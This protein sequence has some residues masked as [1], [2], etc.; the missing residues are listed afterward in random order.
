MGQTLTSYLVAS[1]EGIPWPDSD[2]Y[3]ALAEN[4]MQFPNRQGHVHLPLIFG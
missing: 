1:V 3:V 4:E 2:R